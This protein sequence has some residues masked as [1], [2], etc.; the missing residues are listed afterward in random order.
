MNIPDQLGKTHC[1]V[2][3]TKMNRKSWKHLMCFA[4]SFSSEDHNIAVHERCMSVV[5]S[6][7]G[8]AAI[9]VCN[10]QR[11]HGHLFPVEGCC[12][13]GFCLFLFILRS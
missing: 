4:G 9:V 7:N 11:N 12:E 13:V 5:A 8:L 10:L 2:A 1:V 3:R 6:A